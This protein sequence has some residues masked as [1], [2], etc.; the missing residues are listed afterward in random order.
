MTEKEIKS[1]GARNDSPKKQGWGMFFS[2]LVILIWAGA[3]VIASQFFVGYLM[4]LI[5]G[6]ETFSQPVPTAIYSA[7]SYI[8][9]VF[10]VVYVP[11]K[12][13]I[14]WKIQNTGGAVRTRVDREMLGL[15]G[16]PTWTDIGLAPVGLILSLF[17]AAGLLAIF[18]NFPWFNAEEAQSLGFSFYLSGAD[19][20]I[21]FFTL[22]I[23]API[24]E[25]IIFRGWLYGKL[26]E[27]TS[28]RV[29]NVVSVIISSLLTSL[30]FGIVHMQW[31][32]GVT[33][34]A[35]SLVMC[36]LREITGT[37]YAGMLVHI[38]KNGIAF[39]LVY[40]MGMV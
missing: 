26:R 32:V 38:L 8:L 3:S 5:L 33:V 40:V 12:V 7:L 30:L 10:L 36:G 4:V 9:A 27:K 29:S 14:K 39:Y 13:T 1:K 35:M 21:A 6:A 11:T 25:E 18:N 24:A 23:V 28:E 20:I 2:V 15:K 22:A 16:L 17:L 19:R 34:F 31:N 37:I